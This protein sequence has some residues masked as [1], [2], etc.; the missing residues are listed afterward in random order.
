MKAKLTIII[1]LLL[2]LPG[3]K[4]QVTIGSL[5]PPRAGSLLDLNQDGNTKRGLGLPRVA[6]TSL[7]KLEIDDDGKEGD[8]VGTMVYNI[9]TNKGNLQEGIYCWMGTTWKQ[10]VVVNGKNNAGSILKS[11]GDGTYGWSDV[12]FPTYK[13]HKPTNVKGWIKNNAKPKTYSYGQ[14][15]CDPIPEGGANRYQPCKDLFLNEFTYTDILNIQ[16]NASTEKYMMLGTTIL[17]R[18]KTSD[19]KSPTR[20][21]WESMRVEAILSKDGVDQTVATH[22]ETINVS[23]GGNLDGYIDYFS[24]IPLSAIGKGAYEL[25]IRVSNIRNSFDFNSKNKGGNFD[26]NESNFY[27]INLEDINLV[28]FEYD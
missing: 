27:Y 24:I 20:T 22:D 13:Y 21:T 3:A 14:I 12:T 15:V 26:E 19:N 23:K 17:V 2:L 11:N 16:T 28:V 4:A 6:L 25:K 10:A 1:I 8:Y 7:T 18:K 9:T 5:E